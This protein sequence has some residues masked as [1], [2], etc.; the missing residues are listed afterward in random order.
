M[1]SAPHNAGEQLT[2]AIC[3]FALETNTDS[4]PA[5]VLEK[6]RVHVLDS[7][8]CA[9]AGSVSQACWIA[10]DYLAADGGG[11]GECGVLGS[12]L[13]LAPRFA[14]FANGMAIHADSYD[15]TAPQPTPTRNGGIHAT[16]SVTAACL[17]VAQ[18]LGSCGREV[19]SAIQI[20]VEI[21]S[22]LNH[23]VDQ[24]HYLRGFH[25]TSTL[26]VFGITAAIGRLMK[27]DAPTMS[28]ALGLAASQASGLRLNLGAM[29]APFHSG[30]AAECAIVAV[31]LARRGFTAA[32]RLMERDIGFF[33]AY[34]GGYEP[35]AII[36]RLGAPWAMVDPGTWIKPYPCG[37]LTHPAIGATIDLVTREG[38]APADVAHVAVRTND[39]VARILVHKRPVDALQAKFCMPYAIATAI[40]NR[41]AGLTAFTDEAVTRP[42]IQRLLDRIE[43]TS[44]GVPE[45]GYTN[46]TTLVDITLTDGRMH[47]LR[48][49]AAKGTPQNPM[50]FADIR[51][52][53]LDCARYAGWPLDNAE[54]AVDA[55]AGL[56]QLGG[57]DCIMDALSSAARQTR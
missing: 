46:V 52:K 45:P 4:V 21:S 12:A 51:D 27:L 40:A 10:R 32:D 15:D 34:A 17:A 47:A 14:A 43:Y 48:A 23:A 22:K 13:R 42:D 53:M 56:E 8:A 37:A 7:L 9:L 18:K 38:I 35:A 57:V 54:R 26:N 1:T 55:V 3:A 33:N 20:G 16:G 6:G 5:E 29:A 24:D 11:A 49:D 25:P 50:T 39:K 2:Q 41:G 36:G 28:D 30:H 19:S 44:Y 31:E